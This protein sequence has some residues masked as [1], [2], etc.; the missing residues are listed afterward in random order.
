MGNKIAFKV[1][2]I[3][4]LLE[5]YYGPNK[6]GKNISANEIKKYEDHIR[7]DI[8]SPL[9]EGEVKQFFSPIGELKRISR[10]QSKTSD[11][12][13]E[14]ENLLIEVTSINTVV[15]GEQ[16][17]HGNIP[18]NLPPNENEFI[19]K[20]NRKIGHAEKKEDHVGYHKVVVVYYDTPIFA[21]QE[22]LI[23]K[24][25]DPDFIRKTEFPSSSVDG[26]MFLPPKVGEIPK[27]SV[28]VHL[29]GLQRRVW[30]N[31]EIP[32]PIC[33]AKEQRLADV[34]SK[35]EELELNLLRD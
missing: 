3:D 18:I 17:E 33:Y 2:T 21:L 12:T 19:K 14:S 16:D 26:L 28:Q 9:R 6:D 24:L 8:I 5:I 11:F 1:K 10:S 32:K 27:L 13:I 25:S 7:T 15:V 22:H 35:I 30:K 29:G 23:K 20:I 34:L 4:D 31:I